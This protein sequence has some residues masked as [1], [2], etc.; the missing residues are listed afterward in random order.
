M[1]S[2]FHTNKKEEK[3]KPTDDILMTKLKEELNL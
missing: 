1:G 3:S 2:V